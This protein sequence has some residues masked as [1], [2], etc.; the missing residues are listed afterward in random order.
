MS[1]CLRKLE[2]ERIIQYKKIAEN[3]GVSWEH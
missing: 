2:K 1:K 3:L